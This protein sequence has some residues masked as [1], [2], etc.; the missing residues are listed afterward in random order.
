VLVH[1]LGL[2]RH[3]WQ[4]TTPALSDRYRVLAYDLFGHGDSAPPP[5]TPSLTLFS[6]QLTGLMDHCGIESAAIAGFSLGGMIARR[7]AQDVP[8]RVTALAILHSP[9]R[10]DPAARAAILKRVEQARSQGPGATVEA[11]LERWF[12]DDYRRAN[13][14]MM[15]LVRSW[16]LANDIAI[17]HTIYRVLADGIDEITV[18]DPAIACPAL[19]ITG[20]ED[21]GNGPDM[22]RAIAAEIAGA[23]TC[24]LPGLRHMALAE[25]PAAVNTPLRGF[26]DRVQKGRTQ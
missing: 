20:D 16:V 26:L 8:G 2:N 10:R 13:P 19:V 14:A 7:V 17:Y 21:F 11:A 4:W 12:T 15:D 23:E 3:C 25:D 9:H 22:T 24:I 1:G 18:P 5:E 6:R